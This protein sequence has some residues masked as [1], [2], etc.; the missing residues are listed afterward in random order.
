MY[1]KC[2]DAAN[3]EIT[4]GQAWCSTELTTGGEHVAGCR[5]E[6][7]VFE[8]PAGPTTRLGVTVRGSAQG[9]ES[10]AYY[11]ALQQVRA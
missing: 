7:A 11:P 1:N 9:A 4:G 10:V 3:S 2:A 8:V 6:H 5:P